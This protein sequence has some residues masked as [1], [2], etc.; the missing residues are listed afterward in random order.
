MSFRYY[1]SDLHD[2]TIKGTND[3]EVADSLSHCEEYF[4]VDTE[5]GNWISFG[6]TET[7]QEFK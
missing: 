3:Q 6:D 7:I 1:I 5:T 2:G 4:V